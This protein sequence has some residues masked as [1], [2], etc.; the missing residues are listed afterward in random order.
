[1]ARATTADHRQR[2]R[3]DAAARRLVQAADGER[4]RRDQR[5]GA[6]PARPR[7]RAR[8]GEDDRGALRLGRRLGSLRRAARDV[9]DE[10]V[11]LAADGA[12]LD[13]AGRAAALVGDL[14]V[15]L[16]LLLVEYVVS[17]I[18]A[19]LLVHVVRFVE[20]S[21]VGSVYDFSGTPRM[22]LT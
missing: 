10:L 13:L 6:A 5:R 8:P 16:F 17:G 2:P 4:Q 3:G 12:Q 22:L 15:V 1:M 7:R 20:A 21:C 19:V 9:D 14:G 18:P 11:V